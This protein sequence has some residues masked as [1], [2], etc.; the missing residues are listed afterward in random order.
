MIE[1]NLLKTNFLGKDGFRWWIGQVAPEDAQGD[2]I[3]QIGNTWGSRVKVRIY[4]Y[5][6]PNETELS[7]EDLPWAQV[8]LSPQ[9]GSGK[10]NRARSLRISPGDTVMGFFLDG[11]DAQQP[12]ILGLFASTP[13][14]YGGT[15]EYTSPFQP[16]TGYTSK[17]K[18]NPDFIVK[19][20][21]GDSSSSS[22]K[23]PRFLTKEIV[24]D[25][26][27]K[28]EKG[29]AQ[30]KQ[31][32]DSGE[33]QQSLS[34][35]SEELTNVLKS[36]AVQTGLSDTKEIVEGLKKKYGFPEVQAFKDIGKEVVLASG[37]AQMAN[38][39]KVTNGIKNTLKNSLPDIKNSVPKDKF[40]EISSVSKQLV[41]ST[42]PMIKDMVNT[43][44]DELAPQLNGGLK[45]LYKKEYGKILAKTGNIALAKKAAT[46]AQVAEIPNVLNIQDSM[47]CV[48]KNITDKLLG[49][50]TNLLTQF[51]DNVDNFTDCIG[52]QFI[53]AIFNDVIKGIDKELASAIKGVA[54]IFPSGDIEG[55]LRGKAE[56]ILG[57]ASV[58]NDC[59][60]PSADLGA[61][62]NKWIIGLGP[63]SVGLENIA[64][65]IL[66]IANAAQ[67]LKEAAA[68]PG[69]V[70]GN[71]GL[72]DFMRPDVSSPGFS[73]TLS[74]CYTGPP[75]NCSGI[76]INIFGGGGQ[77][78]QVS[79]LLG[80]IVS[81]TFA[82]QTAS[83]IGMRVKNAGFGY[84]SAPFVEIT[85]TCR[86]GYGASA[87]AVIDYDPSSPTFEQVTDVYIVN[88]GENYP[89]IEPDDDDLSGGQ[90]PVDHVVVVKPGQNYKEEDEITDDKGNIYEK[91]LDDKGRLLNVIP[92]N[93]ATNN[94]ETFSTLP[95]LSI[96]TSTGSGAFLKAQLAPRPDYQ[97][98]IKQVIDCITPRNA[99]I[100]GFINGEPYYGAFHVMSNGVKMT[101]AKHTD[102][103]MIIYDTPQESRTSRAMMPMSTSYTTVSSAPVQN[104]S[105][106]TTTS[107][108]DTSSTTTAPQMDIPDQTPTPPPQQPSQPTYTPPASSP[109]SGG[110]SSGSGG[111]GSSGGGGYGGGY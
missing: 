57:I 23:S 47:P 79:P 94:V 48:V 66:N 24:E 97:G 43:T 67:E 61:K 101:G 55:L 28:L 34:D 59:D 27:E 89:V 82:V 29:E 109:P 80:A 98:E 104:V 84:K 56:G 92:P 105:D 96:S 10:A 70:I 1:N 49:D 13:D 69:G 64:G 3:N 83:L 91:F 102:S 15:E 85:D 71:L 106:T 81:D 35:A 110:G 111:S 2:Q 44:F 62:T 60:I 8:L 6:P 87:R 100:V 7:N 31:L 38:N 41:S 19:N 53:G 18:P 99:N 52:D 26:N 72:F 20:E 5:H 73:S 33:L 51:V 65:Q 88:A 93:P 30:L 90:Y 22:Q 108:S 4:G 50:V 75:L 42:K 74:D 68:S 77:G 107:Q 58:F 76:K 12:V 25:L 86:K 16:F 32:I 46:A 40:K 37:V 63:A 45:N 9:G 21:G 11:E 17:I 54:N 39:T 103:D 95:E 36:G 78:A 14:Y